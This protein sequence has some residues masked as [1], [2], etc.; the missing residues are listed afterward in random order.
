MQPFFCTIAGKPHSVS[1]LRWIFP[2]SHFSLIV[3]SSAV[4]SRSSDAF[5]GNI[6]ATCVRRL[7]SLFGGSRHLIMRSRL[8]C[9]TG[10][11]NTAVASDMFCSA[12]TVSCGTVS[13]QPRTT[14]RPCHCRAPGSHGAGG[15]PAVLVI[16][17]PAH[18]VV[19]ARTAP[20]AAP[21]GAA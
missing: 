3:E 16:G 20:R 15:R 17:Q 10:R 2:V 7:I 4:T 1:V 18:D 13:R 9:E 5:F 8:R 14:V 19:T 6:V 21:G 12:Q 11:W